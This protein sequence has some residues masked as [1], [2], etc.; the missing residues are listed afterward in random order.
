MVS[1]KN[2][3]ISLCSD[4]AALQSVTGSF[5]SQSVSVFVVDNKEKRE[6][7]EPF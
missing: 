5:F 1:L 7:W 3:V 2:I 4:L 6:R